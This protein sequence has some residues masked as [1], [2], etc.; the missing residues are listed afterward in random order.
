MAIKQA[1]AD[2]GGG[3]G[4]QGSELDNNAKTWR[5]MADI[6]NGKLE[7][8]VT[9]S[10]TPCLTLASCVGADLGMTL[11]LLS[12]LVPGY[13]FTLAC[14]GYCPFHSFGSLSS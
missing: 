14:A 6:L 11:E 3:G 4:P 7:Q 8:L 10:W 12:P 9:L 5:L 2:G 1:W 13:F